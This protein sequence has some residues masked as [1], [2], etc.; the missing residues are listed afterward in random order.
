MAAVIDMKVY[1]GLIYIPVDYETGEDN[2][3]PD[4]TIWVELNNDALMDR[5]RQLDILFPNPTEFYNFRYMLKQMAT[6]VTHAE[7]FVV[8]KYKDGLYRMTDL[9]LIHH[10]TGDFSPNYIPYTIIDKGTN[11][12][13][14]V[15]E[16]K[17]TLG[18]WL[19][20]EAQA[21]SLLHHLATSLQPGWAAV[22]YLIFIGEGRNGKGTLLKMLVKLLGKSNVSGVQRQ[23]MA[24]QRPILS[25][26]NNK[27]A[28]IVF[29]GPQEYIK[30]SGPEKT[31]TAGEELVIELKYENEPFTVQTFALFIE[32]LNKE[33]KARDKS[34]A[35]QK[36]I[37]RFLFPNE[38]VDD[39][40][41][42]SYMQSEMMLNA[43]LTLLWE[44]WVS[45][46]ELSA[47]LSQSQESRDLQVE[48][49]VDT[50]PVLA[51]LEDI[52]RKDRKIIEGLRSGEYRADLIA[53]ALQPWLHAQG[54][55]DRAVTDIWDMLAEHFVIKRVTR[56]EKGAPATRRLI[57]GIKPS[58]AH[59][60]KM[61]EQ[62]KDEDSDVL[63]G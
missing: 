22:K 14:Y 54:Y 41:F 23:A 31:L 1:R 47:K 46:D 13:K 58:T 37:V 51:F 60:L 16:L 7:E 8:I 10:N 55:G 40:N 9:G 20:S 50:S 29:D 57:I 45:E 33:P 56:R 26:L 61:F 15:E 27:L 59:A 28:N 62:V 6:R 18:S 24:A 2:P 3:S 30:E 4:R 53:D 52:T 42:L 17:K 35:L 21:T 19:N 34:S 43:L 32:A 25:T 48:H 39:L 12:Y 11:D 36:R 44:H 63:E 38:Y 5:T 49:I